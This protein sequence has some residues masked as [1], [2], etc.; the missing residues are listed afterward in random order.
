MLWVGRGS[1][2]EIQD[3]SAT[4]KYVSWKMH[5]G[6]TLKYSSTDLQEKIPDILWEKEGELEIV[7]KMGCLI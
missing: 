3:T 6:K 5:F 2:S 4:L 7:R 1:A